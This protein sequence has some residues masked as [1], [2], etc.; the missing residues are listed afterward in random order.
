MARI[1]QPD[2][3]RSS[4]R[5]LEKDFGVST[6]LENVYRLMDLLDDAAIGLTRAGIPPKTKSLFSEPIDRVLFD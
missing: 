6:A 5:L 4:V 1:A 2:S 3:K